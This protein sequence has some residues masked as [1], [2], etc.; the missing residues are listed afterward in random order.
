[1]GVDIGKRQIITPEHGVAIANKALALIQ[2]LATIVMN[3]QDKFTGWKSM[4]W[5]ID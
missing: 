3:K 2:P 5:K 1:M 4:P